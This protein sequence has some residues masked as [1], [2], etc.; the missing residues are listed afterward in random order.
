MRWGDEEEGWFH[1][2]WLRDNCQCAEC[3]HPSTL[4]LVLDHST[5]PAS[6]TAAG[7][8]MEDRGLRLRWPDGHLSRFDAGWLRD[9]SYRTEHREARRWRST[10]W[11]A[12]G[13]DF[14]PSFDYQSVMDRDDVLLAWLRSVR[15]TGV[16]LLRGVPTRPGEALRVADR[17]A[18][19]Q[20]TNFGLLFDVRSKPDPTSNAYT[21]LALEVHT[22]LPHHD[23]P[24]GYQLFHCLIN[25]PPGGDSVI[26]DGF[27]LA[28]DLR[29]A[30]AEAFRLLTTLPVAFR[31]QDERHDHRVQS[32]L[33][34]LD[35]RGE[36]ATVRFAPNVVAPLDVP[37]E[38]MTAMRAAYQS[39]L[40]MARD[41][42]RQVRFRLAPGD[43]MTNDNRR[44]LH[45]RTAFD[46]RLGDRHLQGCYLERSEVFSRVRVLERRLARE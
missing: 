33:I 39:F 45:G 17:V 46:P 28:R 6:I 38:L 15:D 1:L 18:F 22:D 4:E 16:A 36:V 40:T 26:V 23:D 21:A 35:D 43:L 31:Y 2:A 10:P 3:R 25:E 41:P 37:F 8:E 24:P 29:A 7:V 5:V 13:R 34:A 14:P 32:P 30:D 11:P 20:Q 27:A 9:H 42:R 19:A 12:D 44:V